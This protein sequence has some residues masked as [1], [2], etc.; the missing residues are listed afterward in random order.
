MVTF[1]SRPVP[2]KR[3]QAPVLC[4]NKR[5]WNGDGSRRQK[6]QTTGPTTATCSSNK[7]PEESKKA[8]RGTISVDLLHL[9]PIGVD[10][11]Y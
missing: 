9:E 10:Y 8:E 2:T 6:V 1:L 5:K 3:K 7:T 4:N 11:Q